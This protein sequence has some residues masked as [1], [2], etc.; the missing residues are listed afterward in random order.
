MLGLVLQYFLAGLVGSLVTLVF[1]LIKVELIPTYK[2]KNTDDYT[3]TYYSFVSR[4]QL[5]LIMFTKEYVVNNEVVFATV[6]WSLEAPKFINQYVL[7]RIFEWES[8]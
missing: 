2:Y 6:E 4:N 1:I 7:A 5:P 3:K 8:H